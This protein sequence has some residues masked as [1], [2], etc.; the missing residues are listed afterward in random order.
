MSPTAK[1]ASS[2][3]ESDNSNQNPLIVSDVC[4]KEY[5]TLEELGAYSWTKKIYRSVIIGVKEKTAAFS[6]K[7]CLFQDSIQLQSA[8]TVGA[9]GLF[10]ISPL[11]IQLSNALP[12]KLLLDIDYKINN[13]HYGDDHMVT[14]AITVVP[15]DPTIV[16]AF[17]CY[18]R[19]FK[20]FV[21]K[22][23]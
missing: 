1:I 4:D 6:N 11:V 10:K 15:H 16:S 20:D 7:F 5:D 21:T 2:D 18:L 13:G 19:F 23:I 8:L 14:K 12:Y 9:L 22:L 3:S 17:S